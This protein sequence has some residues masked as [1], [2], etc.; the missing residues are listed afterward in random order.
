MNLSVLSARLSAFWRFGRSCHD[1]PVKPISLST[2]ASRELRTSSREL[3]TCR[4]VR[5]GAAGR[6]AHRTCCIIE[7][8]AEVAALCE[9]PPGSGS[10][11]SARWHQGRVSRPEDGRTHW[12]VPRCPW[13]PP[14]ALTREVYKI[15]VDIAEM[16][17][18]AG[19]EAWASPAPGGFQTRGRGLTLR[20]RFRNLRR[21]QIS[22]IPCVKPLI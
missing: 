20:S 16:E 2:E 21:P 4:R 7:G 22:T 15:E 13:R 10:P 12:T 14:Y 6:L 5:F 3:R 8:E 9:R 11:Q 19:R 17:A 18:D 1:P